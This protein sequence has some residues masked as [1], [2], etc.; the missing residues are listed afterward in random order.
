MKLNPCAKPM[1][2]NTI[3]QAKN[4]KLR[5]YKA[6]AALEAKSDEKGVPGKKP[7][8]GKKGKKAVGVKEA[9]EAIGGGKG[10]SYQEASS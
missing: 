1:R 2:R 6:A 7:V 4:H 10:C 8:A 5:V 3:R 9:E